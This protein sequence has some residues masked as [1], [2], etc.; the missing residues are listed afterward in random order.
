MET[1]TKAAAAA[2]RDR[3]MRDIMTETAEEDR[4]RLLTVA[5]NTMPNKAAFI[6]WIVV[7]SILSQVGIVDH[8]FIPT[9]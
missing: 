3:L 6:D 8:Y 1:T 7:V 4:G 2:D 9:N 5:I